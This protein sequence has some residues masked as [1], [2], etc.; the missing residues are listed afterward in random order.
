MTTNPMRTSEQC[1]LFR[2][3]LYRN[4]ATELLLETTVEGLCVPTVQVPQHARIAEE[5]TAA[6]KNGW[7]LTT[8]CL[9]PISGDQLTSHALRYQVLE[10][11]WDG[12]EP[13]AGMR[14]VPVA[15]QSTADFRDSQD[16]EAVQRSLKA[17]GQYRRGDL[18]GLF[19]RPGWLGIVMDWVRVQ[20]AS[21]GFSLTGE[22]RQLNASPAF[23]L[24]RFGTDGPALWFKAVGEPNIREYTITLQLARLVPRLV[25]H[26]IGSNAEWNAW[27]SVESEGVH[28]TGA[29]PIGE[30]QQVATALANLQIVSVGTGIRLIEAGCKDVRICSLLDLVDPFFDCTAE[31][32]ACQTRPSP[33]PLT[34]PEI[35][36][37]AGHIRSVLDELVGS[38]T[39]STLG[40][41]DFNLGNILVSHEQCVFL[42]W[43]EGSVGHPFFTLQYLLEHCRRLN[44]WDPV[45]E[46]A[47][48][49]AYLSTWASF[50]PPT[51]ISTDL[52]VVRLLAVF[53]Y[54]V[55]AAWQ[56]L[57]ALRRPVLAGYL[58]SLVRRMKRESDELLERRLTC[59]S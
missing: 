42:D 49:S 43:A 7:N 29:S 17:L 33:P 12:A 50:T 34:Y 3:L 20:A 36:K 37:L 11:S 54:A 13:P 21:H 31:L 59:V 46:K 8:V 15:L 26:V 45:L 14:W 35:T 25:P 32:M 9:F 56:N 6:I 39:P 51:N 16:F 4:K 24:I 41:L 55:G 28:L 2:I 44:G 58:R 10:L 18:P 23:S 47:L 1:D 30:W 48:V 5:V 27:L 53:A 40:H 57:D 22:F 52:Q 19:G 38:R